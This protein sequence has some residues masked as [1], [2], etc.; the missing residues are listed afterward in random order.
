MKSLFFLSF[1]VLWLYSTGNAKIFRVGYNG[2]KITGVDYADLQSA[3]DAASVG[4]TLMF[5]P[6]NY[7]ISLATKRLV[8]LGFGYFLSGEGSN[9]AQQML[10][11]DCSVDLS[12][13]ATASGSVFEGIQSLS[14]RSYFQENVNDIVIRRCNASLGIFNYTGSTC[15]NWQISQCARA[16]FSGAWFG[17]KATN[18]RFDNCIID[19]FSAGGSSE[20]TGLFNQCI[21]V[22]GLGMD[23]FNNGLIVQNSILYQSSLSNF[24]NSIFQ[25]CMFSQANPGITG[26]N[27][28]F[29]VD[30]SPGSINA[31]F[32][33]YPLNVSGETN[34]GKYKLKPG[35][36]AIGAGIGGV[37]LGIF[38]G[39][40][41]YRLSGIPSIPSFY[42]LEASSI[43][44]TTNPFTVT[45]STRSNN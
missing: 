39:S 6:G 12:L 13:L 22:G 3:H 14:V 37:D 35:S 27:N 18:F 15:N 40:N 36:P 21:F 41:P 7:N 32:T 26:N 29:N 16:S 33:G 17:G 4:D 42:K 2:P 20:H 5:Y 19:G 31:V 44:A 30:F 1:S 38:G 43:N 10:T 45:F 25:H 34:D 24:S 23:F 8:Y 28:L 9:P 11:G